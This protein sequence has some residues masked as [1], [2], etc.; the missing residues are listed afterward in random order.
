MIKITLPDQRVLE[1]EKGVSGLEIAKSI[2]RSLGED[3]LAISIN[4]EV[5]DLSRPVE[6]DA[7]IKIYTWN[8]EAGKHAFW[9]SSAHLMAEA[10]E[11]LYPGTKFGIGPAIES[12][13]YYDVEFPETVV[14]TDA[15]LPKIEAK[16]KELVQRKEDIVRKNI[17]KQEALDFFGKKNDH[18]KTEL[19]SELEDGTI[20]VYQQG[21]FTDLCRGPHLPNTGYI[22]AVKL[23]S[24]AGA[25]WRG[26]EKRKQLK[27][28]RAHV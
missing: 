7:H 5:W 8:D 27:I 21:E 28:G 23:M 13:F 16:M 17:S 10:I 3:A 12:G 24:I 20:S 11:Q 18:L 26:D 15:D 14:I 9:H 22:K 6:N 4:G 25:Y 19:I 2:S 1:F